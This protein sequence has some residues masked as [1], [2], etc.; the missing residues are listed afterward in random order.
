MAKNTRLIKPRVVTGDGVGLVFPRGLDGRLIQ[1]G[2][3][4]DDRAQ[5]GLM[6]YFATC[7]ECGLIPAVP[8]LH[9][10]SPE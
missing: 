6:L 2:G 8:A 10:A 7:F 9:F 3:Q 1:R 4:L 5:A